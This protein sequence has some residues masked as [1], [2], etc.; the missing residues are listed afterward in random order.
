MEELVREYQ[1]FVSRLSF[2]GL[3]REPGNSRLELENGEAV[4]RV[5]DDTFVI[6][7]NG[8]PLF[9]IP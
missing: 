7:A 5:N 8:M 3:R 1:E 4:R 2:S 6:V 9:R